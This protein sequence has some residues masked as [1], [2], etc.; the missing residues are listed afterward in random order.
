MPKIAMP[1]GAGA[2]SRLILLASLASCLAP[3]SASA[4]PGP[5]PESKADPRPFTGYLKIRQKDGGLFYEFTVI[6]GKV[7][8]GTSAHGDQ[9]AAKHDIVGGWYDRERLMLLLQSRGDDIGDKWSSHAHQF[10]RAGDGFTLEHTLYGYGKTMATREVYRPHVIDRIVEVP[11][12]GERADRSSRRD[13]AGDG[14]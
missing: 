12:E 14:P 9:A 7:T 2:A 6:R 3:T 4:Q 13:D 1:V 11:A 8:S 10:R 5:A